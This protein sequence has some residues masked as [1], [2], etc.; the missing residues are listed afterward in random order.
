MSGVPPPEGA[1]KTIR[2][3]WRLLTAAWMLAILA[4]SLLPPVLGGRGGPVWHLV[5][6]GVLVVLMATWQPPL[7]AASLAWVYG[8]L[9][10][11]LQWLV[12]YRD[13]QVSDLVA[14]AAAVLAGLL[15]W[16]LAGR[17]RR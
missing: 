16:A 9:M 7:A 17:R 15:I 14:N 6:Y 4:G 12:R 11:G 13:A 1:G 3:R 10:E 8:A 2:A 5:G